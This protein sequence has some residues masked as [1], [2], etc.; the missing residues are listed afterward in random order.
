MIIYTLTGADGEVIPR[1]ATHFRVHPSITVIKDIFTRH[2][3]IVEI[4]CH[5]G[6]KRIKAGAFCSCPRLGRAVIP[7]VEVV[8]QA[9]F[10]GCKVLEYI[11]CDKLE[12]V[13]QHAFSCCESLSSIDLPSVQIVEEAAFL[14][15]P[16]LKDATFGQTLEAIKGCVFEYCQ[17]LERTT[18]PLKRG[19]VV[20]NAFKGCENLKYVDLVE[21]AVLHETINTL[22]LEEWRNDMNKEVDSIRQILPDA[23]AGDFKE[24]GEKAR[25]IQEW[26]ERVL[27]KIIHY[28]AEHERFIEAA[29]PIVLPSNVVVRMNVFPF[30]QLPLYT[31]QG[32]DNGEAENRMNG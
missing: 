8:E 26:M 11:E 1:N 4:V 31:F 27:D 15:C 17:S 2:P 30:L 23:P 22:Q 29:T 12:R 20:Y 10:F 19:V 6:V 13:E 25:A 24:T 3:N 21:G 32:E 18:I 5:K 28:K 14:S 7:G 16:V 9:A